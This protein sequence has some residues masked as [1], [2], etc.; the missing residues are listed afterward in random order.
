[1]AKSTYKRIDGMTTLPTVAAEKANTERSGSLLIT[2]LLKLF[3][4]SFLAWCLALFS[5]FFFGRVTTG[6][7]SGVRPCS[8]KLAVVTRAFCGKCLGKSVA[9]CIFRYMHA[10][11]KL[12]LDDCRL[13]RTT[14]ELALVG[15]PS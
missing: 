8:E 12:L 10:Q 2:T 4:V 6:C 9:A 15:F 1:M 11:V 14:R 3:G 13:Q 5:V 7:D